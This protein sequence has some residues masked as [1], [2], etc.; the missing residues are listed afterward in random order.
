MRGYPVNLTGSRFGKLIVLSRSGT[1]YNCVM[2]LC[3]C[4]CGKK[5]VKR[6]GDLIRGDTTSCGCFKRQSVA[7]KNRKHGFSIRGQRRVEYGIW[8]NMIQRCE[9]ENNPAYKSYGG[10]G[11]RVCKRWKDF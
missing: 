5:S 3:L 6:A 9:N 2:Y 4:D 1:K 7:D 11:I 10:R 8:A